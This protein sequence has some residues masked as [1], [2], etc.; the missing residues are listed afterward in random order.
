MIG[1]L[2]LFIFNLVSLKAPELARLLFFK[3]RYI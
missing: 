3:G 1:M 2:S